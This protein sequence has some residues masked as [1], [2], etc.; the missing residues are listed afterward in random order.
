M[1]NPIDPVAL[2]RSASSSAH[3]ASSVAAPSSRAAARVVGLGRRQG[4]DDGSAGAADEGADDDVADAEPG[5]RVRG[6]ARK[7]NDLARARLPRAVRDDDG[8][9]NA[10]AVGTRT[11][12]TMISSAPHPADEAAGEAAPASRAREIDDLARARLMLPCRAGRQ[13]M[14]QCRGRGDEDTD[15]NDVGGAASCRHGHR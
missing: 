5:R 11:R 8:Y 14:P 7:I 9:R 10:A 3:G 15:Y 2:L 6:E 13:R 12:T 1:L 4:P